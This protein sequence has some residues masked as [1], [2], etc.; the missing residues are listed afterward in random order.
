MAK[1][2]LTG[3][4]LIV[5]VEGL[6]KLWSFRSRLEIPLQHVIAAQ[7]DRDEAKRWWHGIRMPG[8]NVPGI[9]TAGTF[10]QHGEWVFWDVHNPD[11]AISI[12]FR[13]ERFARLV[14]EVEHPD[15][16][17]AAI[18]QAVRGSRR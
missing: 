18:E 9:I 2:E 13:D 4:S 14:I 1:V 12:Q 15:E 11:K 16:V 3:S 17:I 10:H 5:H 6:D 7:H 8:T